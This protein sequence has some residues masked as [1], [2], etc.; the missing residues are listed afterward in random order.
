MQ[1]LTFN[2]NN[3]LQQ[4]SLC[5]VICMKISLK[6][7][8]SVFLPSSHL[9]IPYYLEVQ[10]GESSLSVFIWRSKMAFRILTSLLWICIFF[11]FNFLKIS[12]RLCDT[13]NL[14]GYISPNLTLGLLCS[15]FLARVNAAL[16]LITS[17][18]EDLDSLT[19][20]C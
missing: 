1:F 5:M 7:S 10:H 8:F 20:E 3:S 4:G 2:I 11:F 17:V 9:E 16:G 12:D 14:D 18:A 13:C 15:I 6:S 19:E